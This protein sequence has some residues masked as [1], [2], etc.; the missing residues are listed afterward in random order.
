MKN[1]KY[2]LFVVLI[3]AIGDLHS[4]T[5][6]PHM[7]T[8]QDGTQISYEVYGKGEPT[9]VFVHGWSCDSRYWRNQASV[10]SQNNRIVLIDLAGHGHSGITRQNYTMEAFGQDVKAVVDAIKSPKVILIG[11]S[12]GGEVIAQAALLM[13]QR[14][15]GLIGVDT[16]DNIE[17][18]VTAEQRDS[19]LAPMK[20]D[21]ATNAKQ[22]VNQM[23]VAETD[24][25]LRNLIVEDMSSA[26]PVIAM[27]SIENLFNESVKGT[28]PEL[29]KNIKAP[30]VDIR[31]DMWPSDP[32]ANRRHMQSFESIII[33]GAD[34]FLMM[35][36]PK[37]FNSAL[38]QTIKTMTEE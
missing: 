34:H 9:L 25:T 32:E 14:V 19:F 18:K 11:H 29:F 8:S 38:K 22:F 17:R 10:F 1:I 33:K 3:F 2:L 28:G 23:I 20:Q 12:M 6:W 26:P 5:T 15:K 35:A 16:Y 27:S 4:Q 30:V 37:E 31:A 7:V 21:F 36:R 24:S 13:P